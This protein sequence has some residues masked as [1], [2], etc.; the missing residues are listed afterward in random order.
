MLT[1]K[2]LKTSPRPRWQPEISIKQGTEFQ[3][4]IQLFT[5]AKL[6]NCPKLQIKPSFLFLSNSYIQTQR[7][8]TWPSLLHSSIKLTH[9]GFLFDSFYDSFDS[10]TCSNSNSSI[11][12]QNDQGIG[13]TILKASDSRFFKHRNHDS[14]GIGIDPPLLQ[15]FLRCC[16]WKMSQLWNTNGPEFLACIAEGCSIKSV[17]V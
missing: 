8:K 9:L 7:S 15:S 5:K 10:K 11:M 6:F 13:I 1:L 12:C 17:F 2:L 16:N 14:L 4:I 3:F